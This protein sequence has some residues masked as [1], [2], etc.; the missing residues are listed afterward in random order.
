MNFTTFSDMSKSCAYCDKALSVTDIDLMASWL[1]ELTLYEAQYFEMLCRICFDRE[2]PDY[3]KTKWPLKE[4]KEWG[5]LFDASDAIIWKNAGFDAGHA[6]HW[7]EL[8]LEDDGLVDIEVAK[9]WKQVGFT[10]ENYQDWSGWSKN[11]K[12][13][14]T[15]LELIGEPI[16]NIPAPELS[17]RD[18][19]FNL[20]EAIRLSEANFETDFAGSESEDCIDNWMAG[21]LNVDELIALKLQVAEMNNVFEEKH[22]KCREKI[23]DW[24]P[25]FATHLPNVLKALSEVGLQITVDNLIGYW[26]LS[27]AQILK[28]IDMGADVDFARDIN[29]ASNLVRNG[30]SASKVKVVEHLVSNGVEEETALELTKRGF[31]I[32][33]TEKIEKNGYFLTALIDA[34]QKLK[35]LKVDAVVNWLLVDIGSSKHAWL[36]RIAD[37]HNLGFTPEN[38]A[39]WYR[40]EFSAKDAKAWVKSGAK[41]PAI[42]KRRKAAGISPKAVT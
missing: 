29:F 23:K 20:S 10:S 33:T 40:E 13:I 4:I 2:Y 3:R 28:A 12:E 11:P 14:K 7:C 6:R 36:N 31:S 9:E 30:I 42:A 22:R 8:L 27:K 32:G 26:G 39:E 5:R 15:N 35:P 18:L 34:A 37:W 25:S 41:T 38:A 19:G 1:L 16:D 17:F 24:K 21:G